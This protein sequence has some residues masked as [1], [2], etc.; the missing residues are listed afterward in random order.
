[1]LRE[2]NSAWLCSRP[3]F[4]VFSLNL[5][6]FRR[7]PE[8]LVESDLIYRWR[9]WDRGLP[10]MWGVQVCVGHVGHGSFPYSPILLSSQF[11]CIF[12]PIP[13]WFFSFFHSLFRS[14]KK[15]FYSLQMAFGENDH[16]YWFPPKLWCQQPSSPYLIYPGPVLWI[17][18]WASHFGSTR[19]LDNL[20]RHF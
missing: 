4:T 17:V 13:F 10:L 11:F 5:D 6:G 8:K 19:S 15:F 1:M 18:L 12:F 9:M 3:L 2:Q 7:F 20:A 14:L 16:F